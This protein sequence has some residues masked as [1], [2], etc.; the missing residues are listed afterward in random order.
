M[1]GSEG[2]QEGNRNGEVK[3]YESGPANVCRRSETLELLFWNVV[4]RFDWPRASFLSFFLLEPRGVVRFALGAAFLRAVRFSAF[5]SFLSSIFF[6]SATANLYRTN[7]FRVS[8]VSGDANLM[9]TGFK[10]RRK[11]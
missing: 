4:Q 10:V 3:I 5:R 7:L 6:V 1:Q 8:R 9:V 11:P 2:I